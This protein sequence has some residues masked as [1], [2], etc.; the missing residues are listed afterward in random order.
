M[1]KTG[2]HGHAK[3]R[4]VG[5]DI[6]TGKKYEDIASTS[7]NMTKPV[8]SVAT[9]ALT[10]ID[11]EGFCMLMDDDGNMK[12][13]VKCPDNDSPD[14]ELGEQ[15]RKAMEDGNEVNVTVTSA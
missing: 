13:D 9:Y 2:K 14:P 11:D 8:V 12:E 4:F 15:I 10:D 3:A 5:V 1:G 6:F 7:H